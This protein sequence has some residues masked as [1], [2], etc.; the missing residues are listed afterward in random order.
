MANAKCRMGGHCIVI[1]I[2]ACKH[3]VII[4]LS[5]SITCGSILIDCIRLDGI[6][7]AW[8]PEHSSLHGLLVTHIKRMFTC[9]QISTGGIPTNRHMQMATEGC[10]LGSMRAHQP[11]ACRG[12]CLRLPVTSHLPSMEW[13]VTPLPSHHHTTCSAIQPRHCL[14]NPA[15]RHSEHTT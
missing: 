5:I 6:S 8:K 2:D 4:L 3:Y 12:S 14:L 9:L 13:H 11:L 15:I 1:Q 7:A 10:L